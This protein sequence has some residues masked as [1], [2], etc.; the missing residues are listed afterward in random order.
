MRSA[1]MSK[2]ISE[3]YMNKLSRKLKVIIMPGYNTK[4]T[5]IVLNKGNSI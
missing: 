2:N 4:K 3:N 1:R 5:E